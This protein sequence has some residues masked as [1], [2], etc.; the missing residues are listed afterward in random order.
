MAYSACLDAILKLLLLTKCSLC[1][2]QQVDIPTQRGIHILCIQ[3]S[4]YQANL[5]KYRQRELNIQYLD[6]S[7]ARSP[8]TA[9]TC[10]LA[11]TIQLVFLLTDSSAPDMDM[12]K[13]L[14]HSNDT[15]TVCSPTHIYVGMTTVI[16]PRIDQESL[17]SKR[18]KISV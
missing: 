7:Y 17:A 9:L 15:C 14:S 3:I 16:I 10:M 5:I 6:G 8:I 1:L 18:H 4:W 12:L 2:Q 13:L 11:P